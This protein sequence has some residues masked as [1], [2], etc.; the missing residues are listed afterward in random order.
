MHQT[1]PENEVIRWYQQK[2][3]VDTDMDCVVCIPDDGV[4]EIRLWDHQIC[5]ANH[6]G[7]TDDFI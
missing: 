7:I 1:K 5:S 6:P 4:H 3:G 2:C